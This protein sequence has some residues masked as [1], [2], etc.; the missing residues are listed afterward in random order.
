MISRITEFFVDRP[1]LT[2]VLFLMMAAMGFASWQ[3]IPKAED[4]L[5]SIPTYTIVGVYPGAST[6]EIEQLVV[7]PIEEAVGELEA[8]DKMQSRVEDGLAVLVA[9]FDPAAD[10]DD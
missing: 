2:V 6:V 4:P 1:Q 9:E 5:L 10:P 8:L 7:E 3:S